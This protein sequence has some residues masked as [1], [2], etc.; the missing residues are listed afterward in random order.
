MKIENLLG[1][2]VY[3][4]RTPL[5]QGGKTS[6][7]LVSAAFVEFVDMLI[8]RLVSGLANVKELERLLVCEDRKSLWSV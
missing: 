8:N 4:V 2:I 7:S 3:P 1:T 5:F 6:P